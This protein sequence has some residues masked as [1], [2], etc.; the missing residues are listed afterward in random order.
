MAN[1]PSLAEISN[2]YG[3]NEVSKLIAEYVTYIFMASGKADAAA[4]RE[5]K[6]FADAF[7]AEVRRFKLAEITLFFARY[8]SGKYENS[9][10]TFDARKIG[11]AFFKEF[12]PQRNAEIAAEEREKERLARE[13]D[14][15]PTYTYEQYKIIQKAAQGDTGAQKQLGISQEQAK[16]LLTPPQKR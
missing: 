2:T 6:S 1:C 3:Q 7:S 12:L 15:E 13:N 4:A 11:H 16:R 8:R 9:F 5:I 14:T 10:A